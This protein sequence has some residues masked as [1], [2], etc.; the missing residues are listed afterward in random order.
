MSHAIRYEQAELQ[1]QLARNY[2]LG[3]QSALTRERC[4]VLRT[5]IPAFDSRIHFWEEQLQPMADAVPSLA[6]RQ[7]VWTQIETTTSPMAPKQK[8]SWWHRLS[9]LRGLAVAT[10][11]VAAALLVVQLWSPP[12]ATVDYVAVLA[13]SDGQAQFVVTA[14]DQTRQ[15]DIK[16]YGEPASGDNDYQLW[17]VSKT[18]G[19]IRS[20][21]L[22]PETS[23][24]Q[25]TLNETDWR[26]IGD[27]YELLVTVE[28]KGGSAIGEPSEDV[29]SRGLCIRLSA[30]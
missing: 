7:S 30:G 13:G 5:K 28:M 10:S 18:D 27:A 19:E 20:L 3:V 11:L 26:L 14:S 21:G 23:T 15:L 9:F 6:P 4:D 24:S 22:L 1:N 29:S 2:V 12:V 25:Q 17:A 16:A 8:V